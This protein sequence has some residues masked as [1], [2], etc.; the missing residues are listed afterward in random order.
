MV[1]DSHYHLEERVFTIDEFLKEMNKI[2]VEKT[3]L[4]GSMVEPFLEPP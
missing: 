3:A 2:G 1:I 4:M